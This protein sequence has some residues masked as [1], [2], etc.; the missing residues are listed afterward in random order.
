[1]KKT[2][3]RRENFLFSGGGGDKDF[4]MACLNIEL[5]PGSLFNSTLTRQA[6]RSGELCHA[7]CDQPP[8]NA[9]QN[10]IFRDEILFTTP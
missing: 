10:G 4:C 7:A 8:E 1:M 6:C 9:Y 3:S 2:T 5:S